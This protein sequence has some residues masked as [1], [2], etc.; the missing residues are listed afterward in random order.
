MEFYVIVNGNQEGPFTI[1]QLAEMNITPETEVWAEGMDD[2]QQ[3]GDV[4][5][6]TRLLQ[7]QQFRASQ[8]VSPTPAT[9]PP[10]PAAIPPVPAT[11]QPQA[12]APQPAQ[13]PVQQYAP[14]AAAAPAA[15][16]SN[17]GLKWLIVLLI[18]VVITGVMIVT[19]P[20]RDAHRTAIMGS[21]KEWVNQTVE[22]RNLNVVISEVLKW[23]GSEGSDL[24]VDQYLDVDNYLVCSVGRFDNGAKSQVVS[25]GMFNHVFTFGADDI[26]NAMQNALKNQLG[27]GA[28]E[29]RVTV[30]DVD[31]TQ[32]SQ[33]EEEFFPF[34]FDEED[35]Q[36]D[37]NQQQA[38]PG[39]EEDDLLDALVDSMAKRAKERAIKE[40]K[41]WAKRQIDKL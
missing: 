2:W 4:P 25:L 33:E 41:E 23:L 36:P 18:L 35:N 21:T 38:T 17:R 28:P 16:R 15:P 34:D 20:D 27:I 11:Q 26:R 10:A 31:N 3:A 32:P 39:D 7:Q 9:V 5:A 12:A 6:L 19:C 13:Q 8:A 37:E 1:E 40:A 29:P 24:L 22:Q 14:P 30:P